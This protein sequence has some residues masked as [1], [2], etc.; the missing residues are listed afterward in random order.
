MNVLYGQLQN[1][2]TT[3]V[4]WKV[5]P[6][7]GILTSNASNQMSSVYVVRPGERR[8]LLDSVGTMQVILSAVRTEA[9]EVKCSA[10]K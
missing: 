1:R 6:E 7:S 2:N 8:I 5:V 3:F 9:F 4:V 10:N